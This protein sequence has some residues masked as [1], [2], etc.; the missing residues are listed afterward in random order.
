MYNKYLSFVFLGPQTK[1]CNR[2]NRD[3]NNDRYVYKTFS[4]DNLMVPS[5]IPEEL[6]DLTYIEQSCIKIA[7]PLVHIYSRK[8]KCLHFL[9]N[10]CVLLFLL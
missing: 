10:N 5:E 4:K 3:K 1:L 7:C 8:G 9:N 6:K 2:C